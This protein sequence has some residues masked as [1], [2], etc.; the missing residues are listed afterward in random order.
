[1]RRFLQS[2]KLIPLFFALITVLAYGLLLPFAGFYWPFA[3]AAKFLGSA[4]FIPSFA[5]FRPFLGPIFFAT[6]SLIPPDPIL[7]QIFALLI[8]LLAG[9][10]A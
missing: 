5:G 8:R 1:M 7:W 3:W 4:Q 2:P 6:T 10:S 9:L